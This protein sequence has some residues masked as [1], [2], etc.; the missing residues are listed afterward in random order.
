VTT[1]MRDFAWVAGVATLA[2]VLAAAV[3]TADPPYND[4]CSDRCNERYHAIYKSDGRCISFEVAD[5]WVCAG[6]FGGRCVDI[7]GP[8]LPSCT[9]TRGESRFVIYEGGCERLC[10]FA[11]ANTFVAEATAGSGAI[12]LSGPWSVDKCAYPVP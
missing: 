11:G 8:T 10:S 2:S 9:A 12:Y 4:G 7:V 1:R 6:T 5:C 3:V